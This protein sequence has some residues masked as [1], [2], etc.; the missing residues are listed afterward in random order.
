MG[1]R[2][3]RLQSVPAFGSRVSV[4]YRSISINVKRQFV[5]PTTLGGRAL[6]AASPPRCALATAVTD[7]GASTLLTV[8]VH[9]LAARPR[10]PLAEWFG[11]REVFAPVSLGKRTSAVGER[12]Q[13][14]DSE[15]NL[16][17]APSRDV[18]SQ[19]SAHRDSAFAPVSFTSLAPSPSTA[20]PIN[21]EHGDA[22]HRLP[23]RF[24]PRN[25]SY[26]RCRRGTQGNL[27]GGASAIRFGN[28]DVR[29]GMRRESAAGAP[30]AAR[31]RSRTR[32]TEGAGFVA[33][34]RTLELRTFI[35]RG[36][37]A[38]NSTLRGTRTRFTSPRV[39][40]DSGRA[41]VSCYTRGAG[42]RALARAARVDA[43]GTQSHARALR[44]GGRDARFAPHIPHALTWIWR[45]FFEAPTVSG[46]ALRARQ[47]ELHVVDRFF[48]S[49]IND[50][51][52]TF[53]DF[54]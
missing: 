15:C 28:R 50:F 26:T 40:A 11:S 3:F 45:W 49:N 5:L 29:A 34:V 7:V 8:L 44:D 10:A 33:L 2:V 6:R 53:A 38:A 36:V 25:P 47:I 39:W 48:N 23:A 20:R 18:S 37:P 12:T 19:D 14:T 54:L 35:P 43:G 30:G 22:L 21:A 4:S 41:R 24:P 31:V 32:A 9:T 1:G 27:A 51:D 46:S 13:H 52:L 42:V 17:G 16:G